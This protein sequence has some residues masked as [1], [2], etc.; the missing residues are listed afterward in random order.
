M[1]LT[2]KFCFICL[3]NEATGFP[4]YI[5]IS[6]GAIDN[7]KSNLKRLL[8]VE[9]G[10]DSDLVLAAK[11]KDYFL[12]FSTKNK[13]DTTRVSFFLPIRFIASMH[14]T[15]ALSKQFLY[16]HESLNESFAFLCHVTNNR[17]MGLPFIFSK[18]SMA[19]VKQFI[20][21]ATVYGYCST[22]NIKFFAHIYKLR[23]YW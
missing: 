12:I 1:Y 20:I 13:N 22:V 10:G 19:M 11:A 4:Q 7:R 8:K 9:S 14:P 16:W 21:F 18:S 23:I 3:R 17:K 15:H 5:P 6:L 2:N